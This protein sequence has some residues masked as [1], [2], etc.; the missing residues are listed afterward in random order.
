[1]CLS[2]SSRRVENS[3][4]TC[5]TCSPRVFTTVGS[6]PSRPNLRRSSAVKAV[7]L[8]LKAS[9]SMAC[10]R[11]VSD[12]DKSSLSD[13]SFRFHLIRLLQA[14]GPSPET[15]PHLLRPRRVDQL[16]GFVEHRLRLQV[17]VA[18]DLTCGNRRQGG[19]HR[20]GVELSSGKGE[21]GVIE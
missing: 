7:P 2:R 9:N 14:G 6:R 21:L 10:P 8:V 17:A 3:C 5:S 12:I 19:V 1:M 13:W 11:F 4:Q 16:F 15:V 18:I 20:F